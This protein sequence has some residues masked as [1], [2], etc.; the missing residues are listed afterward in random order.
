MTVSAKLS[1]DV[2]AAL[3]FDKQL[4]FAAALTL[5]RLAQA[6]RDD[7]TRQMRE[8]SKAGQRPTRCGP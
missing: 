2:K 7:I 8:K 4:R 6:T 3:S 1:G 5:T